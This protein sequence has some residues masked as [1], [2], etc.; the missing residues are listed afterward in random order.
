MYLL[1]TDLLH[2]CTY[3]TK[4]QSSV[5]TVYKKSAESV[6]CII[7]SVVLLVCTLA[8]RLEVRLESADCVTWGFTQGSNQIF[9]LLSRVLLYVN[10]LV[11]SN[12]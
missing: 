4:H 5:V 6:A 10:L 7:M 11:I 9:C 1:L 12:Y 3:F 2:T 8:G